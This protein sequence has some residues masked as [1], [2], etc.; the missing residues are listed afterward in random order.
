MKL[1]AESRRRRK[2]KAV[3]FIGSGAT[4]IHPR[5][6]PENFRLVIVE[7]TLPRFGSA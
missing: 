3:R 6:L 7:L 5:Q 1:L 4:Y 2:E